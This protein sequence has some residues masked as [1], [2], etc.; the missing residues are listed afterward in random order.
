HQGRTEIREVQLCGKNGVLGLSVGHGGDGPLWFSVVVQQFHVAAF[1]E[2]GGGRR[3]RRALV[4]SA[5]GDL[6]DSDLALLPGDFRPCGLSDGY[7]MAQRE[8]SRGPLSAYAARLLPGI[9]AR[10]FA[11]NAGGEGFRGKP[12]GN[13]GRKG[14][15]LKIGHYRIKPK[16]TVKSDCATGANPRA[17]KRSEMAFR[18]K[19]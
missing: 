16:S 6:L 17:K 19:S 18:C 9:G 4:R 2:V 11:G 5:A 10:G 8:N 7:G 15:D 3:D 13:G 14:A 1:P 12:A